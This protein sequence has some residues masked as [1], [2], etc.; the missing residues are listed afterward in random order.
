M[1]LVHADSDQDSCGEVS[2]LS[3]DRRRSSEAARESCSIAHFSLSKWVALFMTVHSLELNRKLRSFHFLF[4]RRLVEKTRLLIEANIEVPGFFWSASAFQNTQLTSDDGL[5]N[6]SL[7][8]SKSLTPPPL[9]Q[10]ELPPHPFQN[11]L[12]TLYNWACGGEIDSE[13]TACGGRTHRNFKRPGKFGEMPLHDFCRFTTFAASRL[14]PL[15][16]FSQGYAK[17]LLT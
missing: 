16:D 6:G 4:F 2:I 3:A 8:P 11:H 7:K 10:T 9:T 17:P 14:L 5:G 15:H 1:R 12:G 13:T